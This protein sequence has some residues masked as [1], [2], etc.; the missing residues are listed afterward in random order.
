[1]FVAQ[2]RRAARL[3]LRGSLAVVLASVGCIGVDP[4]TGLEPVPAAEGAAPPSSR[5]GTLAPG[6]DDEGQGADTDFAD[7]LTNGDTALEPGCVKIDFLFV[8]DNSLSMGDEQVNL[9]RSFP[10]FMD[11]ISNELQAADFHVMVVDTDALGPIEAID[12]AE[13]PPAT[14]EA[15][16]DGT[17][18]AGKR[19]NR[20]GLACG[21]R[22]GERFITAAESDLAGT[23]RCLGEVGTSGNSYERPVGAL[24]GA[25]SREL[26]TNYG[27]N[28]HFLRRDAVLVVTIVTDED[29]TY[30]DG[31]PAA[32]RERLL[33]VK[34]H[35]ESALVMLALVGDEDRSEALPGGP[36][37]PED[38][39]ASPLLQEFVSGFRYGSLGA[40]CAPDYSPFFA[41]AVEVIG[42]ACR[43]FVPPDIR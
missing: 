38:A 15:V 17:L 27:C 33:A 3:G 4:P 10:G 42:N 16:C 40:V 43:A 21:L 13:R 28:A 2:G 19:L 31:T 12:A 24:L 26:G 32:W 9:A 29:D 36:C 11:V 7:A 23:F 35:D 5:D 6:E 22:D 37:A 39:D 18:G 34:G 41:A 25:T 30:T 14:P 1:M 8:V 20:D